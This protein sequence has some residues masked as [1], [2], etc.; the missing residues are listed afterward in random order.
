[1][2]LG[3]AEAECRIEDLTNCECHSETAIQSRM[4]TPFNVS[5]DIL[6]HFSRA[7]NIVIL[8]CCIRNTYLPYTPSVIAMTSWSHYVAISSCT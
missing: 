5:S 3:A 1:M 8:R 2:L 6:T 7:V 4:A